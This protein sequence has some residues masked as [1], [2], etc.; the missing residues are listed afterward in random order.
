MSINNWFGA[1]LD[2]TSWLVIVGA[3]GILDVMVLAKAEAQ[4]Q[5]HWR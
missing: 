1:Y 5:R 3:M 2:T 4:S